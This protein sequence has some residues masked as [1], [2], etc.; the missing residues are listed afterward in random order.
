M[1][2]KF[3]QS[4]ILKR[5]LQYNN[6]NILLGTNISPHFRVDDVPIFQVRYGLG[7]LPSMFPWPLRL[8]GIVLLLQYQD[9]ERAFPSLTHIIHVWH[10]IGILVY[11]P[12]ST[13]DLGNFKDM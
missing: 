7:H 11:L 3:L 6:K 10:I 8:Q 4:L 2:F 13:F 5:H 1:G 9:P 12:T